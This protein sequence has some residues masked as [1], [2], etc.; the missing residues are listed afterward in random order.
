MNIES[1]EE[2]KTNSNMAELIS[3]VV[4]VT[5]KHFL[6]YLE[7]VLFL[8]NIHTPIKTVNKST[9]EAGQYTT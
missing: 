4:T 9:A 7:K 1:I 6:Q 3:N 5:C 2:Q 8:T